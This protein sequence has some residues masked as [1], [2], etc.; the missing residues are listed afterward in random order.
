MMNKLD[1]ID[2]DIL[3]DLIRRE[4]DDLENDKESIGHKQYEF[5]LKQ[6]LHKL[7]VMKDES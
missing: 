2:I 6:L 5:D 7:E 1:R 3:S 4:L